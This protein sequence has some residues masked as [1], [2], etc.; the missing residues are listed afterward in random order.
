MRQ[1]KGAA[2]TGRSLGSHLC[3]EKRRL[4]GFRN[5]KVKREICKHHTGNK[6]N[7]ALTQLNEVFFAGFSH[8]LL[9]KTNETSSLA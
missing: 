8:Q 2:V 6:E 3:L 9:L 7:L 5:R 4:L 1:N